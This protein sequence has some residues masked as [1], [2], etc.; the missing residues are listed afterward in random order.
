[1]LRIVSVA[2]GASQRALARNFNGKCGTVAYED[3]SPGP[4]DVGCLH[5]LVSFSEP[6]F[7][8]AK[9]KREVASGVLRPA[10]IC[11][12]TQELPVISALGYR[13]IA[14]DARTGVL[15]Q[16]FGARAL[17]DLW[18]YRLRLVRPSR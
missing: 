9:T 17:S 18:K 10:R 2:A 4:K 7:F 3:L 16:S 6:E 15:V 12:I 11:C 14:L 8:E 13:L 1:M 5:K